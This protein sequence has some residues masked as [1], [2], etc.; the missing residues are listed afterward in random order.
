MSGFSG[1][2]GAEDDDADLYVSVEEAVVYVQQELRI[3]E[4]RA[5]DLVLTVQQNL[6]GEIS[7][8][9]LV[10]LNAKIKEVYAQLLTCVLYLT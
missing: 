10:I 5:R 6:L 2:A 9:D 7:S 1:D 3:E 8:L 4:H